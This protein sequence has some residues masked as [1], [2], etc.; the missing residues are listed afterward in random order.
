MHPILYAGSVVKE[1]DKEYV[2]FPL[3][4]LPFLLKTLLI[5]KR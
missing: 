3:S 4:A 2:I 1:F 5:A